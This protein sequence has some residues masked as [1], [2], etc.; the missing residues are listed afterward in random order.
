MILPADMILPVVFTKV[1]VIVPTLRLAYSVMVILA[2][3]DPLSVV[4][5][6][7]N[8]LADSSQNRAILLLVP[9]SR[10][11]I[12][13]TSILASVDPLFNTVMGSLIVVTILLIC[14]KRGLVNPIGVFLL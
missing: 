6:V 8:V 4:K 13:P 5:D 9:P 3:L 10:L 7:T 11:N 2:L 1:A 12:K 14:S